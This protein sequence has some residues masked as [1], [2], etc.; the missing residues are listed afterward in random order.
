MGLLTKSVPAGFTRVVAASNSYD[1]TRA[2]YRCDGTADEVEINAALTFCAAVGGE[3]ILLEGTY[4]IADPITFP[5][6]GL[7]LRGQGVATFIDGDGL[8][9]TEHGIVIDTKDDCIVKDLSIQTEDGGGKTCHCIYIVDSNRF[10]V[11]NIWVVNSDADGIRI[12]STATEEPT[13]VDGYI[14]NCHILA[15]DG[16]GICSMPDGE[17]GSDRMIITDNVVVGAG[18]TG[19]CCRSVYNSLIQDNIC[20]SNGGHGIFIWQSFIGIISRNICFDNDLEATGNFDGISLDDCNILGVHENICSDN[21][22]AGIYFTGYTAKCK[23]TGNTCVV[24]VDGIKFATEGTNTNL[25]VG[26]YC[27]ANT[28]DG[29]ELVDSNDNVINDNYLLEN[30]AFGILIT[31]G[32]DNVVKNNCYWGNVSGAISDGGIRTRL[33]VRTFQFIQGTTFID[34]DGSAK[35]WEI[36]VADEFAIGLTQMPLECQQVVK[37][38]IWAVGL[39]SPAAGKEMLVDILANAG[40][41]DET[42]TTEAISVASKKSVETAFAV[43]DVIH[44]MIDP[45]DNADIGHILGGDSVEVKVKYRAGNGDVETD[46]VFRA[47]EIEYV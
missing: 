41:S 15:A 19:I 35:G 43:N 38:K 28:S 42:Y 45:T 30:E 24:N 33:H 1:S 7:V 20:G 6:N 13:S 21:G 47:V 4:M 27:D 8:A 26:N 22:R 10:Q 31:A 36:D 17:I 44:W 37:I 14:N 39:A 40:G 46:A 16:Y 18:N 2:D 25:I 12:A 5:A 9:N 34:A 3:V 23:I 32:A 29:I 11:E